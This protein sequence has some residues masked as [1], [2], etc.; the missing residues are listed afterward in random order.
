M[1]TQFEAWCA[2]LGVDPAETTLIQ[3]AMD[4]SIG[5]DSS[6]AFWTGQVTV[7]DRNGERTHRGLK[8]EAVA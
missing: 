3:A 1:S 5:P 8:M 7:V 4:V 6:R 2:K